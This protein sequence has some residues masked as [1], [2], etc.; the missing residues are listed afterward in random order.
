MRLWK[1]YVPVLSNRGRPQR[2]L[3]PALQTSLTLRLT[4]SARG[5]SRGVVRRD[6]V[7]RLRVVF[8]QR[9]PGGVGLRPGTL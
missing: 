9:L 5:A 8:A 1:L 6:E 2:E 7:R 4:S 3:I